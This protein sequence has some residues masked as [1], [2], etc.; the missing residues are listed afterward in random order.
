M[1]QMNAKG[2]PGL[3]P[4]DRRCGAHWATRDRSS[5]FF[6]SGV[7]RLFLSPGM[8]LPGRRLDRGLIPGSKLEIASQC[9]RNGRRT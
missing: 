8:L 7:P 4:E 2:V 3:L 5:V 6:V 9:S 1:S